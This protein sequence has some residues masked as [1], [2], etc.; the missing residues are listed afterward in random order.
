MK[1]Y[2]RKK[3]KLRDLSSIMQSFTHIDLLEGITN[4]KKHN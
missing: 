3:V 2:H 1:K 4:E